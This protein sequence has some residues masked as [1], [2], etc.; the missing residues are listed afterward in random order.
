MQIAFLFALLRNEER[1]GAML[2]SDR[3]DPATGPQQHFLS[4][5]RSRRNF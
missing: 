3:P 5:L 4:R 1:G 2:R